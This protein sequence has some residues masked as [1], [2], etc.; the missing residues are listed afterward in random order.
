MT[1]TMTYST[2]SQVQDALSYIMEKRYLT[3]SFIIRELI[4]NEAKR[5]NYTPQEPQAKEAISRHHTH[6]VKSEI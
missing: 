2:N 3:A 1:I 4:L 5:L 6:I